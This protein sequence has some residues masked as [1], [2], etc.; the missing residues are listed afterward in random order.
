M[1]NFCFQATQ[2]KIYSEYKDGILLYSVPIS[3][4]KKNGIQ[5]NYTPEGQLL[6]KMSYV[7]N[8]FNGNFELYSTS[9]FLKLECQFKN[10]KKHGTEYIYYSPYMVHIFRIYKKGKVI[11]EAYFEEHE[12]IEECCICFENTNYALSCGHKVCPYCSKNIEQCPICRR[13][14]LQFMFF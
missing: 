8:V 1:G 9:N 14:L 4:G 13:F 5:I 6:S 2:R 7:D 11:H 10:G 12:N 3:N